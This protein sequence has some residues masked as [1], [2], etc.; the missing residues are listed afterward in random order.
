M[1]TITDDPYKDFDNW[2]GE[3]QA[4]LE[5]LPMCD[6]CHEHIQDDYYYDI[7]GQTLCEECLNDNYRKSLDDYLYNLGDY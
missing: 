2:D 4:A 7:D 6:E 3:Q 5:R 1:I